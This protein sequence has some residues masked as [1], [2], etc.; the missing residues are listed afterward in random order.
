[1]VGGYLRCPIG[2]REEGLSAVSLRNSLW[3]SLMAKAFVQE[4]ISKTGKSASNQPS[5]QCHQVLAASAV[6]GVQ[7]RF[8]TLENVR[9]PDMDNR[10]ERASTALVSKASMRPPSA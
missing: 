9:L 5:D 6:Q 4:M 7:D 2:S 3:P 1:M 10:I 8:R